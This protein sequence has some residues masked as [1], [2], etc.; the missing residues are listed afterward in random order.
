[1]MSRYLLTLFLILQ[2]N[3][4]VFAEGYAVNLQSTRQVGMGNIGRALVFGATSI[5]YNPGALSMMQPGFSY[6]AGVSFIVSE[7][8]FTSLTPGFA[9]ADTD[10]PIG[11]PFFLYAAYK[12][13]EL[14]LAFGLG[15]YTPFGNSVDWGDWA[16]STLIEEVELAEIFVQPTV[17]VELWDKVGIGVGLIMAIGTIDLDREVLTPAGPGTISLDGD[18][19]DLGLNAG[20]RYQP[21]D[22]LALGF[23]YTSEISA[24]VNDGDADVLGLPPVV[25]DAFPFNFDTFD[26]SLPLPASLNWGV[27]YYA[28][29]RL[30]VGFDLNWI[31][32]SEFEALTIEFDNGFTSVNQRDWRNSF[33]YRFGGQYIFNES[34]IGRAGA[35]YDQTPT[36]DAFYGPETPGS[37]RWG[38]SI[39]GTIFPT[40]RLGIDFALL[41]ING[42]ENTATSQFSELFQPPLPPTLTGEY[43]SHAWI[44]SIGV[45]YNVNR[46]EK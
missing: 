24:T 42:R 5:Y 12:M 43:D 41:Y 4:P 23:S 38:F 37:N 46:I 34:F 7:T 39:G 11:F 1:M 29:D 33:T 25:T 28:T 13:E 9:D 40:E 44:P 18:A 3:I 32:W 31:F 20:I 22:E 19:F 17:S 26:A 35:Y 45:S 36:N 21:I 16:G 27:A 15:V 8:E 30:L 6:F 10:N 14:P 2:M